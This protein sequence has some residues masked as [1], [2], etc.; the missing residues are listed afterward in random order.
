MW[1]LI[2]FELRK[3][4]GNRSG[5]V[6]CALVLAM[7]VALTVLNYTTSETRDFFTGEFVQGTKAQ[8]SLRALQETHAGLLTNERVAVDAATLD[9]ANRLGDQT[10]GLFELSNQ[11]VIDTY[12]FELWQQTRAVQEDDYY[13]EIVGTLDSASPRATSLQDGSKA[14]IEGTLDHGFW[15]VLS[16]L[17]SRESL[18]AQP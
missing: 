1:T 8:Q 15:G 2:H 10:P 6:A 11:Q 5:M 18:L 17:R 13:M 16:L 9:R 14:R 4:L 7:L 3:I 12:G